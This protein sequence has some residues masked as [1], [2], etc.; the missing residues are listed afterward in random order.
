M[1]IDIA[2]ET[3]DGQ[4]VWPIQHLGR[5][6]VLKHRARFAG[7][8]EDHAG[9]AAHVEPA[10]VAGH[11]HR[12]TLVLIIREHRAQD[13]ERGNLATAD[14]GDGIFHVLLRQTMQHGL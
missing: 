12:D 11:L 7:Y 13:I 2:G 1:H 14:G 9:G 3:T 4:R 5:T 8:L 10:I 6:V